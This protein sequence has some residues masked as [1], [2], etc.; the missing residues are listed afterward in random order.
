M[1]S[2]VVKLQQASRRNQFIILKKADFNQ[3]KRQ[4]RLY[5]YCT[6]IC[7][8]W[9]LCCINMFHQSVTYSQFTKFIKKVPVMKQSKNKKN[10]NKWEKNRYRTYKY[11][12]LIFMFIRKCYYCELTFSVFQNFHLNS[13]SSVCI[14]T[15]PPPFQNVW[16]DQRLLFFF[17]VLNNPD[18]PNACCD[19]FIL[20][21][22]R[23]CVCCPIP[24]TFVYIQT[25]SFI[26]NNLKC[27]PGS[28]LEMG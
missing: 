1:K 18:T 9:S 15:L 28:E 13:Y 22:K 2:R 4:D 8:Q 20:L 12:C 3:I 14:L 25:K 11:I 23:V 6:C 16:I 17:A 21:E 26:I 7:R 19:M 10:E 27:T 24:S 5:Q